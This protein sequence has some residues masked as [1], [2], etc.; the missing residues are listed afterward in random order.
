M[1]LSVKNTKN[2]TFFY[3]VINLIIVLLSIFSSMVL[4]KICLTN[5]LK[6]S[7]YL[8][9]FGLF[10]IGFFIMFI[11][12][13]KLINYFSTLNYIKKI[14]LN[15]VNN[16]LFN[17]LIKT[18]KLD[19]NPTT[20]L[21]LGVSVFVIFVYMISEGSKDPLEMSKVFIIRKLVWSLITFVL[22]E[23]ISVTIIFGILK[24]IKD[25]K[26]KKIYVK[27]MIMKLQFIFIKLINFLES[28]LTKVKAF[29]LYIYNLK[30][31]QFHAYDL[32]QK[33]R[34]A[35]AKSDFL[36]EELKGNCPPSFSFF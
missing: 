19:L 11:Y 30:M 36:I 10:D 12:I 33:N 6:I 18:I 17:D 28:S 4:I 22:M 25:T 14:K 8:L 15:Q 35:I 9:T 7:N 29:T 31:K 27:K 26:L 3:M 1:N 5:N 21:V 23:F 32:I 20:Y 34:I 16:K 24:L 13:Y 2:R